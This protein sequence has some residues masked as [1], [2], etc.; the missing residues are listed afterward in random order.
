M[1]SEPRSKRLIVL[2]AVLDV[3]AVVVPIA[4]GVLL[5]WRFS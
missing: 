5:F 4:V 2:L 1:A 3:L